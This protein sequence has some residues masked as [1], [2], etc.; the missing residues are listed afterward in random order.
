MTKNALSSG[1]KVKHVQQCMC[2]VDVFRTQ[3]NAHSTLFFIFFYFYQMHTQLKWTKNEACAC[4]FQKS[5]VHR[6]RIKSVQ[7]LALDQI[8]INTF[9][10]FHTLKST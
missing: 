6:F 1:I 2:C 10:W 5:K 7:F 9:F 8:Q 4:V 3:K